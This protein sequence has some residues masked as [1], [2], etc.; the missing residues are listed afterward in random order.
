MSDNAPDIGAMLTPAAIRWPLGVLASAAVA[1][2]VWQ[3]SG[4]RCEL[5]R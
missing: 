2:V 5:L 1:A 3:M 4:R